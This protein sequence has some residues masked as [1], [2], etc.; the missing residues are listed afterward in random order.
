MIVV[1]DF[2]LLSDVTYEY[3]LRLMNEF[4]SFFTRQLPLLLSLM[5][6]KNRLSLSNFKWTNQLD[7]CRHVFNLFDMLRPHVFSN[8]EVIFALAVV[9][10]GYST[11]RIVFA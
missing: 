7:F 10:S 1:V 8:D 11:A 3:Y 5:K 6:G 9:A 2:Y 4:F